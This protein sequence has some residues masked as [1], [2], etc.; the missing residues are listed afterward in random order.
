MIDGKGKG[1]DVFVYIGFLHKKI[2]FV[3]HVK[4][5]CMNLK[6]IL[7]MFLVM[8][9]FS[10]NLEAQPPVQGKKVL[11]AYFSRSGNTRAIAEGI[12]KLTGGKM[13]EIQ[14]SRPYP[15]EYHACTVVAK[16]EK[17]EGTRPA[18]KTKVEDMGQYEVVFVGFPNWWGTMPM[19][20]V[21]FLEGYDLAGKVL[22]PFCTHGGGGEQRC[23]TDFVKYSGQSEHKKGFLVSGSEASGAQKQVELWLKNIEV[24]Q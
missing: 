2:E 5:K 17:E 10:K 13:F 20:V 11:V 16:K 12:Q 6:F 24:I 7:F 9:G 1:G 22:I 14:T 8:S 15:A 18:L 23:F 3:L 4:L 21:S 19:A